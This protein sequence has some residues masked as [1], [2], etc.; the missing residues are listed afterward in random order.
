MIPPNLYNYFENAGISR[1]EVDRQYSLLISGTSF[2][3]LTKP[4][5]IGDGIHSLS[6]NEANSLVQFYKNSKEEI[7][8]QKFVPASGAATRMFKALVEYESSNIG[9]S[10]VEELMENISQLAFYEL[11]PKGLSKEEAVM[12]LISTLQ[13]HKTP[14]GLVLFHQYGSK[15]RTAFEEHWMEAILYANSKGTSHIHFT[16]SEHHQEAFKRIEKN[17]IDNFESDNGINLNINYSNQLSSTD[18]LCIDADKNV[19]LTTE[20]IPVLRPGGHG[21]LIQNLQAIESDLVF[22]KNIDN[23]VH[24]NHIETTVLFKQALAG[25]LLQVKETIFNMLKSIDEDK[26]DLTK[27]ELVG[28]EI[29]IAVPTD[30]S[31]KSESEKLNY[32]KT[33]LNRPIRVCGMVKNEGEPGGGPFWVESTNE[34]SLQIVES[35]QIDL[36]DKTQVSILQQS[37]HFNPVDLVC[38]LTDYRGNKF[39]LLEY[40]DE[41]TAFITAKTVNGNEARVLERPGLWNGAMADWITIFVEVPIETFNPVKTVNDLLKPMHTS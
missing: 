2:S 18:T 28:K 10:S 14:K 37:T 29:F 20:G 40:I 31:T 5:T 26:A 33:K 22:I 7:S 15:K 35:A 25:K 6:L 27:L 3:I 30:Y 8:I 9:S 17:G 23:V 41:S 19:V 36:N 11:I 34:V 21:A 1:S 39:N 12:Y 4:A 13:Y 16:V 38:Y 24:Q 32:W